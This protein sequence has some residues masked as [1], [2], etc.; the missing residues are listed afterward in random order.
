LAFSAWAELASLGVSTVYEA[1]GREGLVAV[2]LIQVVP[3]S[4]VAGPAR[5]VRCGQADNLMVHAVMEQIVPG[6]VVVFVMPESL[7]DALLGEILA[8]QAQE[9]GAAALLVDGAI[10]DVDEIRSLGLPTWTRWV[11]PKGPDKKVWGAINEPVEVGGAAISPGDG[12]V[13][14][15]DGAVVVRRSRLEEVLALSQARAAKE[16]ALR[17]ELRQGKLTYDLHGLREV[18]EKLKSGGGS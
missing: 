7:P 8:I 17:G 3:G 18:A 15:A 13:L 2:P 11:S 9:R 1:S 6:E 14:D 4:R 10:R 5:T 12:I 16:D